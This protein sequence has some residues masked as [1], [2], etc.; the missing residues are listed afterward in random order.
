MA[1]PTATTQNAVIT[2]LV[3]ALLDLDALADAT[4]TSASVDLGTSPG[5]MVAVLGIV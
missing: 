5:D 2:A 4:V 3:D 1:L